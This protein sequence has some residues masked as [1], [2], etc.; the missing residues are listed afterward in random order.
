MY[1]TWHTK[2][3]AE[4]VSLPEVERKPALSSS[5]NTTPIPVVLDPPLP[6][7]YEPLSYIDVSVDYFV[8]SA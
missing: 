2:D 4:A 5:T 1:L 3:E 8:G 6:E 7:I